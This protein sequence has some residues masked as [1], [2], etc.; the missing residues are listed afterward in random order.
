MGGA[1]DTE[2][3]LYHWSYLNSGYH[4]DVL[5]S[6]ED[7]GCMAEISQKLG[8]RMQLNSGVFSDVVPHGCGLEL[9]LTLE[10]LGYAAPYNPR[11]MEIILVNTTTQERFA[12]AVDEDPRRWFP[13]T[14][15]GEI[16]V[17]TTLGVPENIPVGS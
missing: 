8:Y 6:W 17:S 12:A 3:E 15:I 16:V 10:N 4:P 14:E 5:Q 9:E 13:T 2:L 7:D 1:A 11:G